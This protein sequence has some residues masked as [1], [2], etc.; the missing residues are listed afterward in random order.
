MVK[1]SE[2]TVMS[3]RLK[4]QWRKPVK[5]KVDA[6]KDFFS[7]TGQEKRENTQI[8]S[9]ENKRREITN[10][11]L[12]STETIKKSLYTQYLI[13]TYTG[14]GLGKECVYTAELLCCTLVTNTTL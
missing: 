1:R 4:K 9:I 7:Q 6:L 12:K 8:A 2:D 10:D 14:E 5:P 13:I 11:I 3:R